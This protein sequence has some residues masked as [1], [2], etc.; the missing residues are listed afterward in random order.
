M[1][2]IIIIEVREY[3]NI[4]S[5]Q[6]STRD[7]NGGRRGGGGGQCERKSAQK[8]RFQRIPNPKSQSIEPR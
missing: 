6:R 8:H 2:G 3:V 5:I 7:K 4:L 1:G